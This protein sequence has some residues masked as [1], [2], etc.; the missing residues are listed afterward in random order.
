MIGNSD[1]STLNLWAL[2]TF[3][4]FIV[5]NTKHNLKV[6]SA[7]MMLLLLYPAKDLLKLIQISYLWHQ[8]T[9]CH[10]KAVPDTA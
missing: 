10:S 8:A 7:K 1:M 3:K 4:S 5:T 2:K 9:V 6:R